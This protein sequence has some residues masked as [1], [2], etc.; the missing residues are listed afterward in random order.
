[1]ADVVRGIL[2]VLG[3]DPS[4]EAGSE[5]TSLLGD[6]ALA[7][8]R[9][10]I[11]YNAAVQARHRRDA[12]FRYPTLSQVIETLRGGQPSNISDLRALVASQ[13]RNLA[14]ELRHGSTDGYKALWNV[15]S[16]RQPL[17]P[18]PED[19]CR[20]RLLERLR[21]TLHAAGVLA[22]AEGHY[23]DDKR[24]D[25]HVLAGSLALPVEIKRHYNPDLWTAQINQLQRRYS[26]DP[27]SHG[28]GIYLVLWFGLDQAP[29]PAPP[30]GI[31][32]PT[33]AQDLEAA[34]SQ[35][36]ASESQLRTE[37]IVMDCARPVHTSSHS[38]R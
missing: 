18:R 4:V 5:L 26:R 34:L 19:D 14:E 25:I 10:F 38:A 24:A 17:A 2:T 15:G 35:S 28:Y 3:T 30:S 11:A 1:M 36:V 31:S 27:R 21:P 9:E 32:R 37:V 8:W 20:D 6:S 22:E 33:S 7:A 12:E 13:L 16:T 29:I 23:A